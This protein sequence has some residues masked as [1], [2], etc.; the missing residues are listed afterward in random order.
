[1]NQSYILCRFPFPKPRDYLNPEG[2]TVQIF[3]SS[4]SPEASVETKKGRFKVNSTTLD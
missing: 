3:L 4:F 2:G 1:M